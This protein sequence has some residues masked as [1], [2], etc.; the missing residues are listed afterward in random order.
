[1]SEMTER[2]RGVHRI[3]A[4]RMDNIGDVIMTGPAL[5]AIKE[6]L[7]ACHLTLM[8]SPGAQGAGSL[9]PWA[10]EVLAWR[11]LWQDMGELPFEPAREIGLIQTLQALHCDAAVIFTSFSQSPLPAGYACYLA[12]IPLRLGEPKDF[13]GTVLSDMPPSPTALEAHQVERNLRLVESIGFRA[14]DRSLAVR[15]PAGSQARAAGLLARRGLARGA[16]YALLCPWTSCQAR[17]YPRFGAV[18]RLLRRATGL[19]LV[20]VGARRD[21]AQAGKLAEELG[22]G[23]IDLVGE[24]SVAEL[25]ALVAASRLVV[26][27]NT[28]TMHLADALRVPQA[29]LFAG[30]ELEEQWAPRDGPARLLRRTTLCH[31]CFQLTCPQGLACL[32]IEPEK[33]VAAALELLQAARDGEPAAGQVGA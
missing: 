12:G 32:E 1:M 27:N 17:T 4:M 11:S 30:T 2:W 9:L 7:P 16:P 13:G 19:P 29:V 28:A 5:R 33:V 10:D 15:T 3:L 18:G 6:T 25:A 8:V 31:P 26:T 24:T 23:A 21:Q 22:P 20:I 14:A